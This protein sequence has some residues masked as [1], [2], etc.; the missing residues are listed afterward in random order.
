MGAPDPRL[1]N[2]TGTKL[3]DQVS[4]S[5][6]WAFKP[7]KNP[8]VPDVQ[9]TNWVN[10]P[11]DAFI[12]AKLEDNGMKP[13]PLADKRTLIRRATFDLIGLPPTLK[14]TKDFLDD[15]SPDA[16][17]KVVDRL[18]ASPH[19]GERWGRYWLDTARYADTKGDVKKNKEDFHYPYAWTYRDYVI[20]AFNEDKPYNQFIVEQIA[21]DKL[22]LTGTEPERSGGDGFSH[23]GRTVQRNNNDIINDRIDV[24][25]KGFLGLT[26]TCARCHDHKFDPIPTQD[27]YSLH[28]VF[29]SSI[30]VAPVVV[31]KINYSSTNY[32]DFAKSIRS[33]KINW[34][35]CKAKER[36]I[37]ETRRTEKSNPKQEDKIRDEMRRTGVNPSRCARR[38]PWCWWT[39]P[40]RRIR[41]SSFVA[42]RRTKA[43][44][45]RREFLE[46]L[47]PAE[48]PAF[49][50]AAADGWNWPSAS[51]AKQS[52]DR[53]GHRQPDLDASFW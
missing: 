25:T 35:R 1:A 13:S 44:S 21:A 39:A 6:H 26:V 22:N 33:M 30:E 27:Y 23:L 51:P 28:G 10:T 12:V 43:R 2:A 42:R 15:D 47:S 5:D 29:N 17:A 36:P 4:T 45:L 9:D 19:Y 14:E 18:L 40:S 50:G 8:P 46:I 3:S 20:R 37:A 7:I 53:A 41:R 31:G 11:V 34:Q 38:A 52:V 48:P 49:S 24:V 16:F 32:M